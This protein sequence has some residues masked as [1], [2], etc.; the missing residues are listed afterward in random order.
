MKKRQDGLYL[1]DSLADEIFESVASS[2]NKYTD[3]ST[4]SKFF[5][6]PKEVAYLF[7]FMASTLTANT[8]S[9]EF[10]LEETEGIAVRTIYYISSVA[11]LQIYLKERSILTNSSPYN[12]NT[13]EEQ[14]VK[15]TKDLKKIFSKKVTVSKTIYK[16]M[17][18]VLSRLQIVQEQESIGIPDRRFL[19]SR[20]IQ[21]LTIAMLWGY[22]FGKKLTIAHKK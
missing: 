3:D 13:N 1:R 14:I 9:P 16:V 11:G 15:T 22:Y 6:I 4:V 12:W 19:T 7:S 17:K 8:Y 5:L 18:K 20:F 10:T 2:L 21:N